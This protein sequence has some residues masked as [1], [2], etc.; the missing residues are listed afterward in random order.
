MRSAEI[1]RQVILNAAVNL[2]AEEGFETVGVRDIGLRAKVDPSLVN[3]YYG[4]KEELFIEVV[5]ACHADWR[6]LWGAKRDFAARVVKEVLHGGNDGKVLQGILVMLRVT[7]SERARH[8]VDETL[9]SSIFAQLETWLGGPE[10]DVRGRL[11]IALIG[12]M[13]FARDLSGDFLLEDARAAALAQA[14]EA[15]IERLLSPSSLA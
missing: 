14:F 10:A 15:S 6:R 5:K 12:G 4:G 8:L 13:T 1:T 7:G 2:F 11:L 3:R 9:G